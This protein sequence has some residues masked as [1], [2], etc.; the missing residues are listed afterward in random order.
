M[1]IGEPG[2]DSP[3]EAGDKGPPWFARTRPSHRQRPARV[4]PGRFVSLEVGGGHPKT[5]AASLAKYVRM[6]SAPA[7]RI[8][9]SDSIIA[10]S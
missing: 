4:D 5:R 1:D 7:R 6:I 3:A 10:R 2:L 9:V 8:E